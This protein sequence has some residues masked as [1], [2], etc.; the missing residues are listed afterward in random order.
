[1]LQRRRD[2]QREASDQVA[3]SV[4]VIETMLR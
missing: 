1:L 4:D 3:D 2:R